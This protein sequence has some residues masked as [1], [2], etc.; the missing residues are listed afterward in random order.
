MLLQL[1]LQPQAPHEGPGGVAAL[2]E[3]VEGELGVGAELAGVEV[4]Q[5]VPVEE[6]AVHG[7]CSEGGESEQ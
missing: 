4:V 2:L 6:V 5:A 1:R 7:G 3:G